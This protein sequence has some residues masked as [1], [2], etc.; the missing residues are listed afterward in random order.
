MPYTIVPCTANDLKYIRHYI[1]Q[2]ELDDR[3][4]LPEQFLL[5]LQNNHIIGFGRIREYDNCSEL[6]SL[7]V[8]E[9]ERFKG[10]GTALS[11]AL[12][13]KANK[14]LYLVCIIPHFFTP[15]GFQTT[16]VFPEAIK[17]KLAYCRGCLPVEETYVAMRYGI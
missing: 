6:C 3:D 10:A 11:K 16:D 1:E 4:L 14:E 13:N 7:G 5:A 15:L 8:I 12:I 9:P 17:D 2:F